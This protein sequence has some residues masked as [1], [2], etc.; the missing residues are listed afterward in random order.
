MENSGFI[1]SFQEVLGSRIGD[2]GVWMEAWRK[3]IKN[4][5]VGGSEKKHS[6]LPV[7]GGRVGNGMG[8]RRRRGEQG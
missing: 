1:G 8:K 3:V 6:N 2:E 7:A 4:V 5:Q